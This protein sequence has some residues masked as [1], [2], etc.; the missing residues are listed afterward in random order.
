[1]IL[2]IKKHYYTFMAFF[3]FYAYSMEK[4]K[5]LIG[6]DKEYDIDYNYAFD[7]L[8]KYTH[9]MAINEQ[10]L[11]A[12]FL[13]KLKKL[14]NFYSNGSNEYRRLSTLDDTEKQVL[15]DAI[16]TLKATIMLF[17]QYYIHKD[18][19]FDEMLKLLI[20]Q[21]GH[22]FA[23]KTVAQFT[24]LYYGHLGEFLYYIN[25]CHEE[26]KKI[27]LNANNELFKIIKN[28]NGMIFNGLY[29]NFC[30]QFLQKVEKKNTNLEL[31]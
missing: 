15:H 2:K 21:S 24:T 26:Y 10:K 20:V 6:L 29:T 30:L 4:K 8:N 9:F 14:D 31:F 22:Q 5:Q 12:N 23:E 13:E 1:M 28:E 7:Q 19:I 11:L 18:I 16:D 25:R 3:C 27:K 17:D